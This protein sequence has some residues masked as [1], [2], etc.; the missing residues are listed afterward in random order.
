MSKLFSDPEYHKMSTDEESWLELAIEPFRF[1]LNDMVHLLPER[2][3]LGFEE[4]LNLMKHNTDDRYMSFESERI[5][6]PLIEKAANRK[7]S[8]GEMEIMLGLYSVDIVEES[9]INFETKTMDHPIV[10]KRTGHEIPEDKLAEVISSLA[11]RSLE[12]NEPRSGTPTHSE[13]ISRM[14]EIF[15]LIGFEDNA[16]S[17]RSFRRKAGAIKARV[18]KIITEDEYRIRNY[19][20]IENFCKHLVNFVNTGNIHA[21]MNITRLKCM[22]HKGLPIYSMEDIK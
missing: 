16:R 11:V 5:L 13:V 7:M 19:E 15:D 21:L 2:M 1:Y 12:F 4:I 20:I 3:E 8:N 18:A 17:T 6:K 14:N 9:V 22:T 10:I